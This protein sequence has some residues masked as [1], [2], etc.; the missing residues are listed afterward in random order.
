MLDSLGKGYPLDDEVKL[1]ACHH[2]DTKEGGQGAVDD[3]R[4]HMLQGH[5]HA[6]VA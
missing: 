6:F 5:P 2:D 4:K 1:G 3:R